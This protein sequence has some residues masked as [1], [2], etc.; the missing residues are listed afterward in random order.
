[1]H[2]PKSISKIV[3]KRYTLVTIDTP[4]LHVA[5]TVDEHGRYKLDLNVLDGKGNFVREEKQ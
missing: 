4:Y 1:M 2:M 5:V 3:A